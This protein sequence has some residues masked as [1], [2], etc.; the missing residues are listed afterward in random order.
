[1]TISTQTD[2]DSELEANF[3]VKGSESRAASSCKDE[4]V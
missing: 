2:R 4:V 3:Q 1:M